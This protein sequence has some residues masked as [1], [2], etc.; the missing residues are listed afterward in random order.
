MGFCCVSASWPSPLGRKRAVAPSVG[1][2]PGAMAFKRMPCLPHSTASDLVMA[3]MPA[4]DMAEGTTNGDPVHT[5]VTTID[6]TAPCVPDAIQR[7][8]TACVM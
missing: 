2:T 8:P 5:Q 1:I 3:S 4:L 7:L 6:T